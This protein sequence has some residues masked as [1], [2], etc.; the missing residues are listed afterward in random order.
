MITINH[1]T[2]EIFVSK[3]ETTYVKTNPVTGYE[4]RELWINDFRLKLSALL[5]D[6]ENQLQQTNN[7]EW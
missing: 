6:E 2:F 7:A 1:L 4:E 3:D 5:D